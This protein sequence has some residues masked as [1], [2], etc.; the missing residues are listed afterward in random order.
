MSARV[1]YAVLSSH[2]QQLLACLKLLSS[3]HP[4]LQCIP[5]PQNRVL[6]VLLPLLV[7][8]ESNLQQNVLATVKFRIRERDRVIEALGLVATVMCEEQWHEGAQGF[9]RVAPSPVRRAE[10]VADLGS[11]HGAYKAD[12]AW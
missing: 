4:I 1:L 5:R 9:G 2:A 10:H 6:K 12:D 3:L 7:Q 11:T 8:L